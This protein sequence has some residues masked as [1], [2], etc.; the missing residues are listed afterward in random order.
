MQECGSLC[1][2]AFTK[3]SFTQGV[4]HA[5]EVRVESDRGQN[6][7]L[8]HERGFSARLCCSSPVGTAPLSL[9]PMGSV[10]GKLFSSCQ[11][12]SFCSHTGT[13]IC[14]VLVQPTALKMWGE[15]EAVG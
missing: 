15:W 4:F 5:S 12:V 13:R 8:L 3:G 7:Q 6:A 9:H 10:L 14:F 11:A 1:I 2:Q